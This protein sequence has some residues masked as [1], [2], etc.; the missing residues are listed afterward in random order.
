[1]ETFKLCPTTDLFTFSC[2]QWPQAVPQC[3]VNV[4]SKSRE[5]VFEERIDSSPLCWH[6]ICTLLCLSASV[7]KDYEVMCLSIGHVNEYPTM[8]YFGIPRHCQSM[9]A[10]KI[11]TEYFWKLQRKIALWEC[12]MPFSHSNLRT[13]VRQ[14]F[15]S[16]FL[17]QQPLLHT[18]THETGK[19]LQNYNY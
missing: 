7:P 9:I 16:S 8:H 3:T 14:Y 13:K 17:L 15:G 6:I 1:M 5:A 12:C 11:L 4:E 18:D 2:T 10:Y 19:S